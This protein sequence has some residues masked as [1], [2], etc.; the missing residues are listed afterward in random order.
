MSL[1]IGG[2]LLHHAE[3]V[4]VEEKKTGLRDHR[5]QQQWCTDKRDERGWRKRR[6]RFWFKQ[7]HM[8][9]RAFFSPALYLLLFIPL[10]LFLFP[11]SVALAPVTAPDSLVKS[12]CLNDL[13]KVARVE[14][15]SNDALFFF[16]FFCRGHL[17]IHAGLQ[18]TG[19][20]EGVAYQYHF[21]KNRKGWASCWAKTIKQMTF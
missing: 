10:S 19:H 11:F 13:I 1:L 20:S 15:L 2:S 16:F 12:S 18:C 6:R 17:G 3:K 21:C 14:N 8:T 7:I 4:T 9:A 5:E